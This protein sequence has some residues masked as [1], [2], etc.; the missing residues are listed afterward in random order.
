MVDES[1]LPKGFVSFEHVFNEAKK[2]KGALILASGGLDSAYVLW[3]YS[4]LNVPMFVHHVRLMPSLR[5]RHAIEEYL[6]KKQLEYIN[7]P[8]ELFISTVDVDKRLGCAPMRDFFI[9]VLMSVTLAVRN[10]LSYIVVGEDLMF[11]ILRNMGRPKQ[12]APWEDEQ[13]KALA[14]M[15]RTLSMGKVKLSWHTDNRNF[16]ESYMSM[17]EEYLKLCFSC[18]SPDFTGT[19]VEACGNCMA[20]H[21]N[22][23]LEIKDNLCKRLEWKQ[24]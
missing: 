8:H 10:N 16:F 9:P 13:V 12:S 6:L 24:Q 21:R 4:H 7:K 15:V 14:E 11:A 19:H 22:M 1:F 3:Q 18:R 2:G 5:K 20:C 23:M 17:P